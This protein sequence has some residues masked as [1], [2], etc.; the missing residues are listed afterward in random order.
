MSKRDRTLIQEARRAQSAK[1]LVLDEPRNK[2]SLSSLGVLD[3]RWMQRL[4][5]M[6]HGRQARVWITVVVER[7][8]KKCRNVP[9]AGR[10]LRPS[11]VAISS[12]SFSILA[13]CSR[14]GS[15]SDHGRGYGVP[16]SI[17]E[18][19]CVPCVTVRIQSS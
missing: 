4:S 12:R 3:G 1:S 7:R 13:S 9:R 15:H 16:S 5:T 8:A 18:L 2:D 19:L 10:L 17:Y 14:P 6:P 11:L